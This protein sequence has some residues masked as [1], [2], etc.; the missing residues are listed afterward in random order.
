MNNDINW[1]DILE[2]IAGQIDAQKGFRDLFQH[3]RVNESLSTA[4]LAE[5]TDISEEIII[6]FEAGGPVDPKTSSKLA[7]WWAETE[8]TK[9]TD[10]KT[11]EDLE[12]VCLLS[13][14]VLYGTDEQFAR[15]IELVKSLKLKEKDEKGED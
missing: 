13:R 8:K 1:D 6:T 4:D 5:I 2:E 3:V 10:D 7:L 12:L 15:F 11:R 14:F 9:V